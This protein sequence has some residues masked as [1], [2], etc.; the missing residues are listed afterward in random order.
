MQTSRGFSS[1]G[2]NLQKKLLETEVADS[3]E[4]KIPKKAGSQEA[5]ISESG[6]ELSQDVKSI[7]VVCKI[8]QNTERDYTWKFRH[9]H[10]IS[11]LGCTEI[12]PGII[13]GISSRSS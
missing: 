10:V 2:S 5:E 8:M 6:K 11:V 12:P 1:L 4:V 3:P 9:K 7:K 13:L